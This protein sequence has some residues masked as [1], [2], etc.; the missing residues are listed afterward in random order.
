MRISEPDTFV[1]NSL[2]MLRKATMD[3]GPAGIPYLYIN[4]FPEPTI[5]IFGWYIALIA[6]NNSDSRLNRTILSK[7][8]PVLLTWKLWTVTVSKVMDSDGRQSSSTFI[9]G[10]SAFLAKQYTY[11]LHIRFFT[12]RKSD[13]ASLELIRALI[14]NCAFTW[15]TSRLRVCSIYQRILWGDSVGVRCNKHW[16]TGSVW[17]FL[18][19]LDQAQ[20]R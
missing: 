10:S 14:R 19:V 4:Q 17:I 11:S 15:N 13:V 2:C 6:C 5:L 8:F 9:P 20:N 3:A 1:G 12:D 16:Y 7:I 18:L